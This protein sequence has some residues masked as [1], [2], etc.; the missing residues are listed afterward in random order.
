MQVRSPTSFELLQNYPNPFNLSTVIGYNLSR[1]ASVQIDIY[2]VQ[3]RKLRSL[4]PGN[5]TPGHYKVTW[6]A[7]E[8]ASGIYFYKIQAGDNTQT[9]KMLLLR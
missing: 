8:V 5:Q 1:P 2:D 6:E 3:G 9:K 7:E 4:T